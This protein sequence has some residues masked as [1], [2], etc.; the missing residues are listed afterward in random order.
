MGDVAS[1][2][3]RLLGGSGG[4]GRGRHGPDFGPADLELLMRASLRLRSHVAVLLANRHRPRSLEGEKAFLRL[5]NDVRLDLR[6]AVDYLPGVREPK[7]EGEALRF[8]Q[9]PAFVRSSHHAELLRCVDRKGTDPRVLLTAE[10][11]V[12]DAA[13]LDVPLWPSLLHVDLGE[14]ASVW[15]PGSGD[16]PSEQWMHGTGLALQL[17]HGSLRHLPWACW[18]AVDGI[19]ERASAATGYPLVPVETIPGEYELAED[20]RALE[21]TDVCFI[22]RRLDRKEAKAEAEALFEFYSGSTDH[23]PW[24]TMDLGNPGGDHDQLPE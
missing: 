13:K 12:T 16:K 8:M 2:L 7:D 21:V 9:A 19:V 17:G 18:A 23:V 1:L 24:D 4:S 6:V 20:C 5:C 22:G 3:P 11:A 10:R 14:R 15:V